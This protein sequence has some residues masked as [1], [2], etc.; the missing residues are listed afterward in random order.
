[1]SSS[2]IEHI[3]Q[4]YPDLVIVDS[5]LNGLGQNNDVLIINNSLVFRFPKYENGISPLIQE[6]ALLKYLKNII[7]ISIPHPTYYSF[8]R[9]EPGNVFAGYNLI[10]GEPFWKESLEKIESPEMISNLASQ[11]VGFLTELHSVS[12]EKVRNALNLQPNHPKVEMTEL[13]E[14]IQTKLFPYIRKEAQNEI[15]HS[16]ETLING[17]LLNVKTTLIHG[18]FGSSNILWTPENR[19]ISG[20]IDFGGSGIGDPAYDFAGILAS[21]GKE[22]FELCIDIQSACYFTKVHSPYKKHCMGLRIM[23]D[24]PL[25]MVLKIIGRC[26]ESRSD[27]KGRNTISNAE[28]RKYG[29]CK[30]YQKS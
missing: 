18:D 23:I 27:L 13:F 14:K 17:I 16:F 19:R 20:I 30:I 5:Y 29:D 25:K 26:F 11:L 1:M 2:Y 21:Y 28:S 9:L 15:N 7:S 4:V 6:A 22:F 10:K 24:K 12:E 8:K 3:K